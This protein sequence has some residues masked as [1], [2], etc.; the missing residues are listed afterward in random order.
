MTDEELAPI[1]ADNVND[2]I[3]AAAEACEEIAAGFARDAVS[4]VGDLNNSPALKVDNYLKMARAFRK[5]LDGQGKKARPR[6]PGRSSAA[7][8]R[9]Q[10]FTRDTCSEPEEEHDMI[11]PDAARGAVS[12]SL[13]LLESISSVGGIQ[14]YRLLSCW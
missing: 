1:L 10:V 13:E 12:Q 3:T 11:I 6:R 5:R 8:T 2:L 14:F 4:Y 9:G 7:R